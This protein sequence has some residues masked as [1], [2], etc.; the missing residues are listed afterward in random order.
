MIALEPAILGAL[1][2]NGARHRNR[3]LIRRNTTS[4]RANRLSVPEGWGIWL[5]RNKWGSGDP[6]GDQGSTAGARGP[7]IVSVF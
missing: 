3:Q 7:D 2:G 6:R 4:M 5:F 1:M